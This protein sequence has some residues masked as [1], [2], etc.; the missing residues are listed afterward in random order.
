MTDLPKGF[1]VWLSEQDPE[2]VPFRPY[3]TDPE[4]GELI[5]TARYVTDGGE[6]GDD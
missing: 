2:S 4:L 1:W 6:G 5:A 3:M